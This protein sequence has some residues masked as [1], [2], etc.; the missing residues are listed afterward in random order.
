MAKAAI[1]G[2][3]GTAFEHLDSISGNRETFVFQDSVKRAFRKN[4]G[5]Y[6]TG[7]A[8]AIDKD[9]F[10]ENGR[11]GATRHV[12]GTAHANEPQVDQEGVVA[13]YDRS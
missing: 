1:I 11:D 3:E 2:H 4:R 5:R 8:E 6:K 9:L 10:A 7:P 12:A 13:S